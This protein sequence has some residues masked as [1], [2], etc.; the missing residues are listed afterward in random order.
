MSFI[1]F[2]TEGKILMGLTEDRWVQIP[3]Q[4][5]FNLHI[6][7]IC[8]K[9]RVVIQIRNR[10]HT[11]MIPQNLSSPQRCPGRYLH[12]DPSVLSLVW[13]AASSCGFQHTV[14]CV[15]FVSNLSSGRVS[16]H[17]FHCLWLPSYL[18]RQRAHFLSICVTVC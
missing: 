2:S 5:E 7:V 17:F 8:L 9:Q 18:I 15:Q 16:T 10:S 3:F 6:S 1:V 14:A 11:V 13:T 12:C 4:M